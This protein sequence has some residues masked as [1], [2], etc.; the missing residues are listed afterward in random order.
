M[1]SRGGKIAIA[2]LAGLALI[3]LASP[4]HRANIE[5]LA[6]RAGDVAPQ[7]LEAVV[8]LGIVAVSVLVTWSKRLTP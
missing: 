5:I 7:R 4:D 8:D 6:H 1:P 2:A 3:A